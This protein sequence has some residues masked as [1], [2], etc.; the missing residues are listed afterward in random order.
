MRDHLEMQR[1]CQL[2]VDNAV[3]KTINLPFGTSLEELS[4]LFMEFLPDLKGVTVYP[5]GSRENQPL[6][7]LPNE[8]AEQIAFDMTAE[9]DGNDN[10]RSGV[11][12]V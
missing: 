4:D 11:C 5:D 9:V 10:C 8:V 6:T 3:S 12:D 2:H 7:P 1:T